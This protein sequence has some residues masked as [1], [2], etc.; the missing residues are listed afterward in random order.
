MWDFGDGDTATDLFTV[1][2]YK[3]NGQYRARLIV[4]DSIACAD[5]ADFNIGVFCTDTGIICDFY[6]RSLDTLFSSDCRT[7]T[8]QYA[9]NH[10]SVYS[11]IS[12][13]DGL[14]SENNF[15]ISHTYADTGTYRVCIEGKD[16]P[17]CKDSTCFSIRV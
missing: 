13:G 4:Q 1:H 8:F 7:V 15:N 10:S 16:S 6:L 3:R 11:K 12:F 5:T 2:T 9:Y 14:S 17:E